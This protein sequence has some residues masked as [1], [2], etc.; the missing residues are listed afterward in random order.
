MTTAAAPSAYGEPVSWEP[1]KPKFKP[2]RLLISWF[3]TAIA[4]LVAAI[5]LPGV[6]IVDRWDALW[7]AAVVALLNA[8]LPPL[9]AA[10]APAVHD[11]ARL[12]PDPDTE[13]PRAAG[14]EQPDRPQLRGGQLRL[15]AAGGARRRRGERRPVGHLRHQRRRHVHDPGHPA[16]RAAP[17]R[18]DAHQRARDHLPRDRRARAA[19]CCSARCATAARP[20]WRSG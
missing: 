13:R 15:G 20:T 16:D 17:G 6:N 14:R 11:R 19:R 8:I 4:L 3:L 10:L 18:R 2:V 9:L 12:H 1:D 7:M 5:I